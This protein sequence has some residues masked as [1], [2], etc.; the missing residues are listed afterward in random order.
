MKFALTDADL[1]MP[2]LMLPVP[3]GSVNSLI[4]RATPRLCIDYSWSRVNTR[5]EL[6]SITVGAA[7]LSKNFQLHG[8]DAP[9]I[10]TRKEIQRIISICVEIIV[11]NIIF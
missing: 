5:L 1:K 10:A 7:I 8:M 6:G 2:K 9:P 3:H 11:F 4:V